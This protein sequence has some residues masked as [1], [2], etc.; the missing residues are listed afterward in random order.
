MRLRRIS[1]LS[2]RRLGMLRYIL[3]ILLVWTPFVHAAEPDAQAKRHFQDYLA[4]C[5]TNEIRC[6]WFHDDT[7]TVGIVMQLNLAD[8][9]VRDYRDVYNWAHQ[10]GGDRKMS[11]PQLLTLQKIIGDLPPS[12]KKADY[13]WSVFVAVRRDGKV[14]VFQYDRRRV[15]P[16]VQRIYDL[17]GGY[18]WNGKDA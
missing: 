14:E 17:G 11:H 15:P 6:L 4:E 2:V 1:D 12:D 7:A 3:L 5:G 13:R 8:Y 10:G 9:S 18:F 16:I